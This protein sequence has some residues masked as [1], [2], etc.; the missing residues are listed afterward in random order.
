M[1]KASNKKVARAASTGGGRT[2]RGT[3]PVSW[4][5]AMGIIVVIGL[6]L[7]VFSRNQHLNKG[8]GPH[9]NQKDHWHAAYAFDICGSFQ[10][11]LP[12]PATLLG[13]HTHGDGLVHVEP[14]VT[15]APQDAGK[16]ATL[17]RFV[18]GIPGLKLTSTEVQYP[19]G[20][21]YKNG[22]KCGDKVGQVIIR[23]WPD[24]FGDKNQ[25]VQSPKELRIANGGA[26]TIAFVPAGTDVPKPPKA[27]LDTLTSTEANPSIAETGTTTTLPG[28]SAVPGPTTT[29][30][31][32]AATTTPPTTAAPATATTTATT[33]KP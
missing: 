21:L 25:I 10:P 22:D 3:T 32:G 20:K 24:A 26:V 1:G 6:V 16:N 9:P 15:G 28:A 11:N 30:A 27:V 12:Q 13:L 8:A 7:V 33:A 5:S 23:W 29:A 19:G 2:S 4:Y 31:P 18:Q 17:A 14:Y